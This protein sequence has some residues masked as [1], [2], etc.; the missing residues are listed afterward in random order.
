M[1]QR[2]WNSSCFR[3]HDATNVIGVIIFLHCEK[4]LR[5]FFYDF[6]NIQPIAF[7]CKIRLAQT[8]GHGILADSVTYVFEPL[9]CLF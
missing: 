9:S 1:K 4:K 2:F 3:Y 8:Y 7:Y 5:N 6:L